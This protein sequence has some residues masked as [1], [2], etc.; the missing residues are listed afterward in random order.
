MA[1]TDKIAGVIGFLIKTGKQFFILLIIDKPG[2]YE[3]E[4][5]NPVR[6]SWKKKNTL[7]ES[8]FKL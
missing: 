5:K 7:K 3:T 2:E 1:Q 6:I 4:I 8:L